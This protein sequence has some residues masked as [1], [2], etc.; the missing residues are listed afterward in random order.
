[1]AFER[2]GNVK[3]IYLLSDF[4]FQ[5]VI[6]RSSSITDSHASGQIGSSP[7]NLER[8]VFIENHGLLSF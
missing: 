6:T 8:K 5:C 2:R 1:M 3:Y 7:A 4:R